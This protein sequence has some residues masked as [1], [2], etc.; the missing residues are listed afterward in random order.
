MWS[1]PPPEYTVA[2]VAEACADAISNATNAQRLRQAITGMTVN[3]VFYSGKAAQGMLWSTVSAD[4]PVPPF[5]EDEARRLYTNRLLAKGTTARQIYDALVASARLRRCPYC[6]NNKVRTLD[7]FLPKVHYGTISIEPLNLIPACRDC[8]S[9][10]NAAVGSTAEE[11][12]LH[13]YFEAVNEPWLSAVVVQGDVAAAT[14]QCVPPEDMPEVLRRRIQY[15]F[16]ELDLAGLY[17]DLSAAALVQ[18]TVAARDAF[19]AY[20]AEGVRQGCLA[21]AMSVD[22]SGPNE[23]RAALYRAMAASEW[24]CQVGF[25]ADGIDPVT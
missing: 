12:F 8:N 25:N 4:Y 3:S 22:R 21:A 20:E 17:G 6:N 16:E 9:A 24:Y 18:H 5:Q 23:W 15:H 11:E 10:M 7:H 14:F 19:E 2:E 1:T 13:A